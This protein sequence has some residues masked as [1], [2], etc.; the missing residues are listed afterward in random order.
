MVQTFG[1]ADQFATKS[2]IK[3]AASGNCGGFFYWS[4]YSEPPIPKGEKIILLS[5]VAASYPACI[6]R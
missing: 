4:V 6:L 1:F 2:K 5:A 3:K